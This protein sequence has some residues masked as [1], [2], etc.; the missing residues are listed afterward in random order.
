MA[1]I[2]GRHFR[3]N[4]SGQATRGA[5]A[6][7]TLSSGIVVEDLAVSAYEV[8]TDAPESDGTFE[9]SSTTIVVVEA[10]GGGELGLGYTYTDAA[11]GKLIESK[12]RPVVR[13]ADA[14]SPPAAWAAMQA[15]VRNAG[16]PGLA[17]MA[18][19]AVDIALWEL[20][21]RLLGVP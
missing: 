3:S 5:M 9:W 11:A 8:P 20:K 13:G 1:V 16:R 10:A 7:A 6:T 18:I 17:S 12:L 2:R 15:A 4:V 14:M 19:A 21:A